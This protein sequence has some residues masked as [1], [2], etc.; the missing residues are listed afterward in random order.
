MYQLVGHSQL[1]RR[2]SSLWRWLLLLPEYAH[3]LPLYYLFGELTSITLVFSRVPLD[4]VQTVC[5]RS[6]FRESQRS[7]SRRNSRYVM[8]R[9]STLVSNRCALQRLTRLDRV[10]S[11]EIVTLGFFDDILIPPT[12]LPDQCEL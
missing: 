8:K 7:K 1:Y 5:W 9:S 3:F 10:P 2:C 6:H 12:L 4:H 11:W